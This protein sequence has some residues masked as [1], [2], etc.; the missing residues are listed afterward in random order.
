MRSV[1]GPYDFHK[2]LGI[3]EIIVSEKKEEIVW[4]VLGSCISVIFH[5]EGVVSI[6]SHSQLP[7]NGFNRDCTEDCPHP[8][9][10]DFDELLDNRYVKCSLEF[11]IRKLDAYDFDPGRLR[12][13]IVGGA[14]IVR[15]TDGLESIGDR[16]VAMA[17]KILAENRIRINREKTGGMNGYNLWY[18]TA[19]DRLFVRTI[20]EGH[21]PAE[22][23]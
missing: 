12:T 6:I 15:Q 16:N 14:A 22:L 20:N 18:H 17:R 4:T 21:E 8:C 11:M 10:R 3:G 1:Q 9:G 13:S 7:Q 19:T 23:F 5:V 2:T